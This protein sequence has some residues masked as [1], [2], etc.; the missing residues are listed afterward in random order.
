M[1]GGGGGGCQK[2][3][4]LLIIV[5]FPDV[6]NENKSIDLYMSKVQSNVLM[7]VVVCL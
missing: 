4:E 3:L 5:W 7:T 1:D 6:D 2:Y